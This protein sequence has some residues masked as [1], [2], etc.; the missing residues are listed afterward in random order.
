MEHPSF[1]FLGAPAVA[2]VDAVIAAGLY[3]LAR[4]LISLRDRIVEV[5]TR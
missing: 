5:I 1:F 4:Y 2:A 3:L